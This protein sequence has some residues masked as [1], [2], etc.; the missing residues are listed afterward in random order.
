VLYINK[1]P[2]N[3]IRKV[4][5]P[6]GKIVDRKPDEKLK[7]SLE[8][9]ILPLIVTYLYFTFLIKINFLIAIKLI[10]NPP[11]IQWGQT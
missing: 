9:K 2:Y 7:A 10:I 1:L 4:I 6:V 5:R 11:L 3:N 8:L